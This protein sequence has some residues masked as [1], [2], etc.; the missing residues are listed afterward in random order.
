MR[1]V[2][3]TPVSLSTGTPILHTSDRQDDSAQQGHIIENTEGDPARRGHEVAR[4][5]GVQ[6]T[7]HRVT[8]NDD[9]VLGEGQLL[10]GGDLS[11][12]VGYRAQSG[13]RP[14]SQGRAR[15]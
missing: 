2:E 11:L 12:P 6:A 8:A 5:L 10:A 4:V 3:H 9:L 7:L 1:F 13:G 15:S 14:P